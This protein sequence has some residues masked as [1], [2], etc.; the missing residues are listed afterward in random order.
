MRESKSDR[1]GEYLEKETINKLTI[2]AHK[3]NYHKESSSDMPE[4]MWVV[5]EARTLSHIIPRLIEG[6]DPRGGFNLVATR[7]HNL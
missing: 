1:G 7:W 2:I 5:Q 4:W 6:K 3:L